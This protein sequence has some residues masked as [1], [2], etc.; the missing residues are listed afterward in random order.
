M[1]LKAI[2]EEQDT[3]A[4]RI[5]DLAILAVI[6]VSIISFS[7]ETLPDLS[8]RVQSVLATIEVVTVVIFTFEYILRLIVA[9]HPLRF[10]LSFYGLID[11]L[12]ILPFYLGQAVDLRA[13]RIIRLLRVFRLLKMARYGTAL[14][15]IRRAIR[16]I[17]EELI[18]YSI[19]TLFLLYIASIGIYYFENEAQPNEF[20]S[21]FHA[22]WWSLATLTTVGYGDVYPVTLGRIFTG[23]IL[24]L[25]LGVVAVP[26]GLLA[27][28]LIRQRGTP[29]ADTTAES[30][31]NESN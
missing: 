10:A 22:M 4:G 30:Q 21:V 26:P 23:A 18:V 7:F 29:S 24:M 2:I 16:E 20:A 6:L 11:L 15:R 19:A 27:S 13:I 28:A 14:D 5:F 31:H 25:G 3:R 1:R 17:R 12:A 9:D 8:D